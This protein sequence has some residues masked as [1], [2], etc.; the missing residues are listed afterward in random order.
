MVIK[1][2]VSPYPTLLEDMYARVYEA[3]DQLAL[4]DEIP[5]P[6]PHTAPVTVTF[7]GL[8][9]VVH[10][11]RLYTASGTK[12]HE[13]NAEPMTD[14]VTI[15]D[16]IFFKIGD[17]GLDT[18]AINSNIF[19]STALVGLGDND[20][21]VFRNN[22]GFLLPNVH[23]TTN[24]GGGG[25]PGSFTLA[26]PDVFSDQEEFVIQR[27][28]TVSQTVVN[29]S[30]VGKWF[31]SYVDIF[32]TVNYDPNH[33]RCLIRLNGAVTYNLTGS[34]PLFYG[35]V[36]ENCTATNGVATVQFS[37]GGMLRLGS[38]AVDHIDLPW[39]TSA[40]F[41]WD[42]TNWNVVYIADMRWTQAA[43]PTQTNQIVSA[44]EFHIGVVPVGDNQY[45]VT[46]GLAIAGEYSVF[47]S[48]KGVSTTSTPW[49]NNC[50]LAWFHHSTDKPNKFNLTVGIPSGGSSGV[51]NVTICWLIIKR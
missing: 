6:Q 15:F 47:L 12:L 22:Y 39:M 9:K 3:A 1:Y 44:G 17:G 5:L 7:N 37:N 8:D 21:T 38:S 51:M 23:Y 32:D 33:L 11:V 50:Q 30:V 10:I 2:V 4:V 43:S 45:T 46:H 34:I 19:A 26:S 16:P 42:G 48:I 14:L 49:D 20:Y 18:P 40:C 25:S 24:P 41:T 31:K 27:K 36:F 28:S 35:F 13:Y 29:D